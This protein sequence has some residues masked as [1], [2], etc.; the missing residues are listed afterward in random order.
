LQLVRLAAGSNLKVRLL[1]QTP[2]LV[3]ISLTD[4]VDGAKMHTLLCPRLHLKPDDG[5]P[6]IEVQG[7]W[8]L[9]EAN[10]FSICTFKLLK[11]GKYFAGM[12]PHV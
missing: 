3:P 6:E 11:A 1:L 4:S 2:E 7:Q 9:G 8:Q 5:K 10:S 12:N